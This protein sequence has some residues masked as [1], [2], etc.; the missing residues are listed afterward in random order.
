MLAVWALLNISTHHEGNVVVCRKGLYTLLRLVQQNSRQRSMAAGPD[1]QRVSV[2]AAILENLTAATE[3]TA[4]IYKAA[5]RL[6]HAALLKQAGIKRIRRER[7]PRGTSRPGS[8]SPLAAA[9][10]AGAANTAALASKQQQLSSAAAVVSHP[11]APP[12]GSAASAIM[13]F[14]EGGGGNSPG[15]TSRL[16]VAAN[17][18]CMVANMCTSARGPPKKLSHEDEKVRLLLLLRTL[19]QAANCML[20]ARPQHLMAG[21]VFNSVASGTWRRPHYAHVKA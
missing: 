16:R 14:F 21:M 9:T 10:A 4:M 18:A 3:N 20:C 19:C 13:G 11:T 7:Q 17:T 12:A 5:L 15:R 2:V 6:K 1:M 8:P